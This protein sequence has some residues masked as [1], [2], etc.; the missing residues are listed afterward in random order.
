MEMLRQVESGPRS[1]IER[2]DGTVTINHT[3]GRQSPPS[4]APTPAP[5]VVPTPIAPLPPVLVPPETHL[6]VSEGGPASLPPPP[7]THSPPMH[8]DPW[9]WGAV[10]VCTTLA[11]MWLFWFC[12]TF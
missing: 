5:R 6:P 7:E 3:W 12:F 1:E 10:M 4:M 8:L 9:F 2:V 11:V